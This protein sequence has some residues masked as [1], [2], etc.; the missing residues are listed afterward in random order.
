MSPPIARWATTSS[1]D[2]LVNDTLTL[3]R[4]PSEL[5]RMVATPEPVEPDALEVGRICAM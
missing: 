5:S 2:R 4:V 1:E 3:A